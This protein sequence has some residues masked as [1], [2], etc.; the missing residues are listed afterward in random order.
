M[1]SLSTAGGGG[2][3]PGCGG[4]QFSAEGRGI[5]RLRR[6]A[7]GTTAG[8]GGKGRGCRSTAQQQGWDPGSSTSGGAGPGTKHLPTPEHRSGVGAAEL[9][10]VLRTGRMGPGD[11]VQSGLGSR[12]RRGWWASRVEGGERLK[13][14]G[15]AGLKGAQEQSRGCGSRDSTGCSNPAA[16]AGCGGCCGTGNPGSRSP[17]AARGKSWGWGG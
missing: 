14:A 10:R 12:V 13:G 16:A 15:G 8:M 5:L 17:E 6:T 9:G 3:D 4:G 11:R 7:P 1:A 2:G